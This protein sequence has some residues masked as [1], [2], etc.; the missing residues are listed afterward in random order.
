EAERAVALQRL[1]LGMVSHELRTPLASIKGFSSS[2]LATDV[3]FGPEQLQEFVSIIDMEADRLTAL[4][5]QLMDVVQVQ[6]G[7][8]RVDPRPTAMP[9]IVAGVRPQL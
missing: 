3:T 2:I 1:F 9:D 7:M 4:I 5:N 6:A 8:L